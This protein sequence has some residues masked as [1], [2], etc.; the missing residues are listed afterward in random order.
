MVHSNYIT[1]IKRNHGV[2]M[3]NVKSKEDTKRVH[4]T[5]P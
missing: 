2:A 5:T 4:H 3:P 1:K